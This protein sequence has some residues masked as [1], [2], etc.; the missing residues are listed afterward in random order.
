MRLWVH[1]IASVASCLLSFTMARFRSSHNAMP[2]ELLSFFLDG[3]GHDF[4]VGGKHLWA[5]G[6]L[7]DDLAYKVFMSDCVI[8]FS[9][10]SVMVLVVVVPLF[11][12]SHP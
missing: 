10:A 12:H 1:R 4:P 8:F 6:V 2:A 9:S 7:F 5:L 11:A 3:L